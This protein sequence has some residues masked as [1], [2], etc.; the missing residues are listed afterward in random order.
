[1]KLPSVIFFFS[2]FAHVGCRRQG[3]TDGK[4]QETE[5]RCCLCVLDSSWS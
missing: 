3:D 4:C 1:L 5:A 2:L